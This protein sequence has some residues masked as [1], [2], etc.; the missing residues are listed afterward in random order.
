MPDPLEIRVNSPRPNVL[1]PPESF[2]ADRE[3]SIEIVNEGKP[4]H[5]HLNLDN[6]L[7]EIIEME[8]GNHFVPRE[9]TYRIPVTLLEGRR[10]VRG[11][12]KVST[13]YG[14]ESEFIEIRVV[15]PS[16]D[17]RVTVDETLAEPQREP[18]EPAVPAGVLSE[19][20]MIALVTI[21]VI[22]L[23]VAAV[24]VGSVTSPI[25]GALAVVLTLSVVVG[26]YLFL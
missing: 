7:V 24:I 12:L 9:D 5:V 26:I 22:A 8:T 1:E 2:V 15:E 3:F 20:G 13:G 18:R 21:A 25:W 4:V 23:L 10:P 19:V 11:K 17:D 16:D 6:D 14:S